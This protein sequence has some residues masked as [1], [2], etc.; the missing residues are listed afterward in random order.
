MIVD[1]PDIKPV[2]PR[3]PSPPP[4][5]APA[6]PTSGT[7][8][9]QNHEIPPTARPDNRDKVGRTLARKEFV[10]VQTRALENHCRRVA[11]ELWRDDG[12]VLD[13]VL[14]YE[15]GTFSAVWPREGMS[16]DRKTLFATELRDRLRSVG[17]SV[18]KTRFFRDK[19]RIER[20]VEVHWEAPKRPRYQRDGSDDGEHVS[21]LPFATL[22]RHYPSSDLT[23][24][25]HHLCRCALR[26][27]HRRILVQE[28]SPPDPLAGP[29]LPIDQRAVSQ[30]DELPNFLSLRLGGRPRQAPGHRGSP[31]W[32]S[33]QVTDSVQAQAS[34]SRW[35]GA[36]DVCFTRPGTAGC[37]RTITPG[38]A[39]SPLRP[40]IR[41][42][43]YFVP[44]SLCFQSSWKPFSATAGIPTVSTSVASWPRSTPGAF[45]IISFSVFRP[46]FRRGFNASSRA[47]A[48]AAAASPDPIFASPADRVLCVS[49]ADRR[50][51][52]RG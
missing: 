19:D 33:T 20:G 38:F 15:K 41:K 14:D 48:A 11:R 2:I 30:P 31:A 1:M 18:S 34:G 47:Y 49:G 8:R 22:R 51:N 27:G 17:W 6:H 12:L 23:T 46:I 45:Y 28:P 50:R 25:G 29:F 4:P 39:N 35:S 24:A 36:R 7:L 10:K 3:S 13:W 44:P 32:R 37:S 21:Y 16:M 9:F 5:A 42:P 26:R 40:C 43:P 52:A